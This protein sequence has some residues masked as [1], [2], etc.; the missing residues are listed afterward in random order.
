MHAGVRGAGVCHP[1]AGGRRAHLHGRRRLPRLGRPHRP[2]T[3]CPTLIGRRPENGAIFATC[4]ALRRAQ[5]IERDVIETGE[6]VVACAQE[7]VFLL[8]KRSE[9]G[10][11]T[12]V[13]GAFSGP[14][15]PSWYLST[16]ERKG[17]S[18][19]FFNLRILVYLV[20]YD[21]G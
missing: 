13:R 12:V 16:F 8:Y 4:L 15:P 6:A 21:S 14:P 10:S 9:Q 1:R 5:R 11:T 18:L 19:I 20:I 3:P 17:N 2:G 7:S